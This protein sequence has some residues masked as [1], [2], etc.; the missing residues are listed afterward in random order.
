M[1]TWNSE[2]DPKSNESTLDVKSDTCTDE[3]LQCPICLEDY[4]DPRFI[5]CH[6]ICC[7]RCLNKLIDT[8]KR[9]LPANQINRTTK[10]QLKM[11]CPVCRQ[12][13]EIPQGGAMQLRQN[14]YISQIQDLKSRKSSYQRCQ[15]HIQE[16]LSL[17]CLVC[18][19]P[20]CRD[21]KVIGHEGHDT[22]RISQTDRES[23]QVDT[24]D[25]ELDVETK[26]DT[27]KCSVCCEVFKDP[28]LIVCHRSFC[29]ECL[30]K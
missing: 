1:L 12:E 24:N 14:F 7:C 29:L 11:P 18:E 25:S 19:E 9:Q 13:F 21:C 17:L 2:I 15:F 26:A 5:A 16:K 8:F 27:N 28:H 30:E 10:E 22:V 3:S 4:E 20:I 23:L 6:H